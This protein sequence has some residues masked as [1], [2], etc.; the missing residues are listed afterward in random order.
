[1]ADIQVNLELNFTP[2]LLFG[3][4]SSNS[5]LKRFSR[6][7]IFPPTTPTRVQ[8]IGGIGIPV[9]G[10]HFESVTSGY[11]LKAE[12]FLP[13]NSTEITR[14]YL[15]PMTVSVREKETN[16]N[17]QFDYGA[18]YRWI[19]YRGIEMILDNMGLPGRSCLL[20]VICEH[21][22]VPLSNESGLLGEILHITL[23]PSS[24]NDKLTHRMDGEY[25]ESEHYG[26]R[27]GDCN[28]AYAKKCS[29]S[30]MDLISIIMK[31]NK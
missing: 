18:I 26:K 16:G 15:K 20:R 25:Q 5:H 21:A 3:S 6:S 22:A 28:A 29:K 14:V 31:V 23:T 4:Y 19:I 12:Y 10:L 1:M 17:E 2:Q 13:T 11:V 7:L 9:I 27:G 24:S 8:F 30:P